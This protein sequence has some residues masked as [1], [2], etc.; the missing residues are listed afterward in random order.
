MIG[1]TLAHYRILELLGKGGMGEVYLAEDSKLQRR[2]ALKILSP[3][4][5]SDP[6]RRERFEREARAAAAFNHP[7][8]VTI[9]SVEEVN[10]VPFLTLELLDGQTL[11]ALI[12]PDG[13]AVDR[14]L[15]YAIPLADAVGAAH[16]RGITHR[17]LKPA[18]VMV[19][20]DGRL[21]VLDFG[22]AKLREEISEAERSN[23]PTQELTGE[24]R[25]VGTVAYM[26]PE[27][28]EA[29]V[30]DSRT[31]VFALGVMLYEMATGGRPFKGDTQLS[32]LSAILKDTPS[33]VTDIKR[34]LPRELTRIVRRC[35]AKDPEDRY[36]TAKDLRNDLR[37]LRD[38]LASGEIAATTSTSSMPAVSRPPVA[39]KRSWMPAAA[40][41]VAVA[42]AVGIFLYRSSGSTAGGGPA[43]VVEPFASVSLNRLTT[44]GTAGLA[45]LSGD[46]RYAA[47]VVTE[48][49]QQS[50]WLRQVTT[51]SN[52]QIVPP[53]D[54][55][56]AGV[57][58]SPDGDHVYYVAYPADANV[59][60]MFQVPVLG[61]GSR[62]IVEDIDTAPA[63]SPDASRFAFVRGLLDEGSAVMV[64]DASG[65][66]VR[67]LTR[68]KDPIMFT[69]GLASVAWS[70]DGKVL[71]AAGLDRDVLKAS[72]V[73]IDLDTGAE[74]T[75]ASHD[76]RA[77]A[78]LAWLPDGT[79]VLVNGSESG[80]EGSTQVWLV[81]PSDGSVRRIT[82]D[83]ST[84]RGLS[85]SADGT[86]FL[87]V[88][89]ETRT[90]LWAVLDGD[91]NSAKEITA[92]AGTDDGVNGFSWTPDGRIV[93]TS[94]SSGNSD[95]W[96][97]NADG[98]NRVQ[99]TNDP[100]E[101]ELPL[102]TPDGRSVVFVSTRDGGPTLWRVNI[103]GSAPLKLGAARVAYRPVVSFDGQ[104]VY[105]SDSQRQN[106][107]IPAAGGT[108]EPLLAEL[109]AGGR[110][111][112]PG[113]HE[114]I[115]SPDGRALAGHYADPAGG[116]R[117]AVLSTD[118]TASERRFSSV[119]ATARWAPDG[120]SLVYTDRVNLFR[121]PVSGAAAVQIT[122]FPGD[123]LFSFALSNDQKHMAFVRGQTTSDVV[124]VQQRVGK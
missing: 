5:S 65:A 17:D 11:D 34:D 24:G 54:T 10:G 6:G 50:L 107:R 25:I 26:S 52:V 1:Q 46:G 58:F 19:T 62:K 31:D 9:Y 98:S 89:N 87:T 123:T 118:A 116:E 40:G 120:K 61:G 2:V 28:A 16:Q 78:C 81:S 27:Q 77:I 53:A 109:T 7:N 60:S 39:A 69:Q 56:Y 43:T 114:P 104:W 111:L 42:T 72:L 59:A 85:L 57:A 96:I 100:G 113:F 12:P 63:F 90:R 20:S 79:G 36:Q 102:V 119:P 106:F 21:K 68:R 45:A 92:G 75:L 48:N 105:Y 97:M 66:N 80:G 95:I 82:N 44:T 74:R 37:A 103:D 30:V 49:R 70:P 67:E 110:Q 73:L 32:V 88:R 117:I 33:P 84:Y 13:L 101:D 124:L 23:M 18:N 91:M 4:L 71:A 38:D 47:Y 86:S 112:P 115:P 99:L 41:A 29:R 93:Y 108:P 55:R 64:A 15:T 22:L 122:K 76:W 83:L 3:T 121:Q 94:T 51:S 35:L 14:L 8:I